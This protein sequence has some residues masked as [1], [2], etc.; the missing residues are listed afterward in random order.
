MNN[1]ERLT[2]H[3]EKLGV[4]IVK[5]D[6]VKDIV[7]GRTPTDKSRWSITLKMVER[8]YANTSPKKISIYNMNRELAVSKMVVEM[9]SWVASVKR[10]KKVPVGL[11]EFVSCRGI[12]FQWSPEHKQ[13]WRKTKLSMGWGLTYRKQGRVLFAVIKNR[14]TLHGEE[15]KTATEKQYLNDIK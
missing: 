11:P 9:A 14:P 2:M 15:L 1:R 6:Y 12:I 7:F 13:Y 8:K 4:A 10:Q 5:C 3:A